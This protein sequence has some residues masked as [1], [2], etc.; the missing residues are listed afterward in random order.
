M[1]KPML[2]EIAYLIRLHHRGLIICGPGYDPHSSANIQSLAEISGYPVLADPTSGIRYRDMLDDLNACISSSYDTFLAAGIRPQHDPEVIIRLGGVPTSKSLNTYLDS[3][4]PL[5]NIQFSTEGTWAD[6]THRLTHFIQTDTLELPTQ[7]IWALTHVDEES[8]EMPQLSLIP[9]KRDDALLKEFMALEKHTWQVIDNE[10]KTGAYFDGAVLQDVIELIPEFSTLFM[11]NSLPIRLLDQFGK[12]HDK[13]IFTYA[14]RGASGIDGNISTALGAGAARP[15]KP[16]VAVIGD[17]TFYHDMN[18]LLAVK[19]C[20]V[21]VTLVL[22]NNN[23]G[24]I[25]TRL[26]I[27]EYEPEFTEYFLTPHGLDFSHA[28]ALYGLD[29]AK[30]PD[31][32]SFRK[33]FTDSVSQRKSTIIEVPTDVKHDLARRQAVLAAVKDTIKKETL[34]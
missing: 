17:I 13:L 3:L 16:L 33:A 31:R 5:Y 28:A 14:N 25:F 4:R 22:L 30:T 21:P 10:V 26:P 1:N 15:D 19:R 8:Q 32:E 29:Y 34:L 7:L 12:S 6:D 24:G 9:Q 23:G 27:K 20:D 18:G 11:G 2:K